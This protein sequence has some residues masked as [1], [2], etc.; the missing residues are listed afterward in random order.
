MEDQP[1]LVGATTVVRQSLDTSEQRGFSEEIQGS[2][3]SNSSCQ[4]S[5]YRVADVAFFPAGDRRVP[6]YAKD[7][8]AT[9][10]MQETTAA[11]LNECG[12]V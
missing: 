9:R 4:T 12:D 10:M 6:A 5:Q 8:E 2:N 1:S 7:T 11:L 3:L